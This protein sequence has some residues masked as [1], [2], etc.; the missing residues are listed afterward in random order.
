MSDAWET[1]PRPVRILE[2]RRL[3]R[4]TFWLSLQVED[5]HPLPHRP[6]NILSLFVDV[7][8]RRLRHPYTVSAADPESREIGILYRVVKGGAVTPT[9]SWLGKGNRISMAGCFSRPIPALIAP[10]ATSVVGVCT[11]S[12]VGPLAGFIREAL[13]TPG[14]TRPITLIGGFRA[15]DDIPLIE[16]LDT[17]AEDSRFQWFPSLSAP[18]HADYS[19]PTGRISDTLPDILPTLAGA[20]VHLVGNGGMISTIKTALLNAGMP[21]ARLTTETYFNKAAAPDA[22]AVARL[23]GF[24][25]GKV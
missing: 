6:G 11:G 3:A 1:D 22:A 5:D 18:Q 15:E 14:W 2:N 20:H 4:A 16:Q 13:S 19:G 8:G 21:P 25:R 24:Y 23:S 9:L 10:E 7:E 17:M 12:G